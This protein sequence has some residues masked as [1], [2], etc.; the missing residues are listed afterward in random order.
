MSVT[1]LNGRDYDAA[2]IGGG[3]GGL[4]AAAYLAR[5]GARTVLLE[6]REVMGGSAET[7]T[8]APG[9]R[10]PVC[11]HTLFALDR[12]V[13]AELKLMRRGLQFAEPD[14]KLVG[15]RPG[16]DRILLPGG[17]IDAG[18]AMASLR[19]ADVAAYA[20][21]RRSTR[22]FAKLLRPLWWAAIE[23]IER[24][25]QPFTF[26]IIVQRL[27]LSARQTDRL[28]QLMRLSALG[29]LDR[30]FENDALKSVLAFDGGADG[31]SPDEAGSA[32]ALIWRMAQESGGIQGAVSQPRGASGRFVDALV[33][34][35]LEFKAELR[36]EARVSSIIVEEGRAAGIVLTTGDRI[37]TGTVVSCLEAR[38]TL[39]G[40]LPP[41]A[42]GFGAAANLPESARVGE[43]TL[44]LALNAPPPLAGLGRE[45]LR[46]RLIVS[47]HPE[48]A[49]EAKR[50]ALN[51]A[52]PPDLVM[53]VTVPTAADASLAP[54][55]SHVVSVLIRYLPLS[56]SGGWETQG[57]RL[58]HRAIDTLEGYAPGL[59]DR[60][61]ATEMF[62]PDDIAL[63]YG[64]VAGAPAGSL[65]RLLTS[66]GER[67]RAPLPGLFLCGAG[68]EP[69]TAIS[70]RAGR[71]AAAHAYAYLNGLKRGAP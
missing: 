21:F 54:E 10:G 50:A 34:A 46:A 29:F 20:R 5:A 36:T 14:L 45:E 61:V 58:K 17:G 48:S 52:M 47:E 40:L 31:T 24:E 43:A 64:G 38:A 26:D 39:L 69:V 63:R 3:V 2:I 11:A 41:G 23:Y 1:P 9:F 27:G 44:L 32:L 55:G 12:R 60:I 7:V 25:P 8:F 68:A 71:L 30:W 66:Y 35:A 62:K 51:G 19:P 65:S 70:G 56:P 18:R 37:R 49:G 67:V 15:L 6:A 57:A 22:A 13:V 4:A 42:I 16:G 59:R 53:E 28:V 33:A